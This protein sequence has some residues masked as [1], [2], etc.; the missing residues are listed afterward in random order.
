MIL[1]TFS[2]PWT[3]LMLIGALLT[4]VSYGYAQQRPPKPA[5]VGVIH[6]GAQSA[7]PV[8][9]GLRQGFRDLGYVEGRD[10]ILEI[11]TTQGRYDVAL[12]AARELVKGG[13]HILVSAGTV[14]TRAAKA[15]A[16]GLPVVFTQVG[17]PVEAGFVQ[18]LARP[19]GNMTGFSTLLPQTTG[20][21]LEL[22][23]ELVPRAQAVLVMFDPDNPTSRAAAVLARQA[24][25][26]LRV[27]L[28]ERHVKNREDVA[29]I[30]RDITS[31]SL[32]AI[33]ILPDSLVVNMG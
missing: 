28:Q 21:R 19:G 7:A 20:K 3:A 33:L 11:R 23:R 9:I 31:N 1:P 26:G 4:G 15:A 27:R 2:R 24:A 18:S 5:R 12:D 16:G 8:V 22:L 13:V 10:L 32:D 17:E 14:G 30:L 25:E 29:R 6:G